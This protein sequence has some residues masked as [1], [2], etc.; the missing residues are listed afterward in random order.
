MMCFMLVEFFLVCY[1]HGVGAEQQHIV[2]GISSYHL[3][4]HL[5]VFSYSTLSISYCRLLRARALH[6]Y[7]ARYKLISFLVTLLGAP[8]HSHLFSKL[9]RQSTQL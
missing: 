6:A 1:R 2:G 7:H 8:L 3:V 4:M 5:I 9:F